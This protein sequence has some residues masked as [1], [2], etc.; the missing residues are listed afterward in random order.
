M[1]NDADVESTCSRVDN[2]NDNQSVVSD[3]LNHSILTVAIKH[4]SVF[5]VEE[6]KKLLGVIPVVS[7]KDQNQL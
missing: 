7:K 4:P 2:N 1:F 3:G 5:K 6:K